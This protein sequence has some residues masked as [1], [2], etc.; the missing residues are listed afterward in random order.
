MSA[1]C[2]I[3][4]LQV[5]K[6]PVLTMAAL[7]VAALASPAYATD[8]QLRD[9]VNKY[10]PKIVKNAA[11]YTKALSEWSNPLDT[12]PVKI[13]ATHW[14]K[15]FNSYRHAVKKS[16]PPYST[17][18]SRAR[19]LL[20]KSLKKYDKMTKLMEDAALDL[21]AGNYEGFSTKME[22]A[23]AFSKSAGNLMVRAE[24]ILAK[25]RITNPS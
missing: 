1:K 19:K 20:L 11:E 10:S 7:V 18:G 22:Q 14:R 25:S 17:N 3:S 9:A 6:L 2:G 12:P 21:Y 13:A 4:I 16:S 15:T 5:R 8:E 24:R 23:G